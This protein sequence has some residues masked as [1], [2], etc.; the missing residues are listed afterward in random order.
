M[1]YDRKVFKIDPKAATLAQQGYTPPERVEG[2]DKFIDSGEVLFRSARKDARIRYTTDGTEPS[3][4]SALYEGP[5]KL[6]ETATVKARA[7]WSDGKK[8][9]TTSCTLTKVSPIKAVSPPSSEPGLRVSYYE[10]RWETLPEFDGL[11]AKKVMTGDKFDLSYSPREDFFALKFDGYITLPKTGVYSFYCDSDDGS[12]LL[13]GGDT[14]VDNDGVHGMKEV[15]GSIA[16]E[17]GSHPI[18]HTFFQGSGGKG[19]RIHYEGPG[20]NK[21]PIPPEMLSH[22]GE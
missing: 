11:T 8:S 15:R 17:A 10:G 21:Q 12:R 14:V 16:L 19:L 4:K 20:I 13:V 18:T 9:R 22:K 2:S 1:T 7:F 5:I 6:T 3:E